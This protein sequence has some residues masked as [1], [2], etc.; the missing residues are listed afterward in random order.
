MGRT[1]LD[2]L[3][4]HDPSDTFTDRSFRIADVRQS[5][6]D[7]VWPEGIVFLNLRTE[8][9]AVYQHGKLV[10]TA[11]KVG[12]SRRSATCKRLAV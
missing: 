10:M 5:A 11:V 1:T 7:C 6:Q 2:W 9:V 12:K 4:T 8:Q 3:V